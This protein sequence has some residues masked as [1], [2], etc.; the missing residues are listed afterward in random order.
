MPHNGQHMASGGKSEVPFH[1]NDYSK[2]SGISV[3]DEKKISRL[4]Y[5]MLAIVAIFILFSGFRDPV[6][7]P[8]YNVR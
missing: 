8:K 6:L 7:S 1:E 4:P 2:K 3:C 5:A